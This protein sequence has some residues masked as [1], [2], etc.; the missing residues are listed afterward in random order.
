M[1]KTNEDK[2]K[3]NIKKAQKIQKETAEYYVADYDEEDNVLYVYITEPCYGYS[4]QVDEDIW[5]DFGEEDE[6]TGWTIQDVSKYD[7]DYLYSKVYSSKFV[8]DIQRFLNL[9]FTGKDL[10]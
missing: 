10:V 9:L 4:Y 8:W 1:I 7:L 2:L 6:L 3:S 5:A